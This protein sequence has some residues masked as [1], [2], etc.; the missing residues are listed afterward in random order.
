MP[1]SHG[2][3]YW[4]P[5]QA[6][7]EINHPH[8]QRIGT[9]AA[10]QKT[11][12]SSLGIRKDFIYS[13]GGDSASNSTYL[14]YHGGV[15]N[16]SFSPNGS[17]V[18]AATER[19]SLLLFDPFS[20]K[21]IRSVEGAHK[22]SVNYVKFLD[23]RLFATCSDDFCVAIWDLRNTRTKLK[24]LRGHSY[25][26]KNIEYDNSNGLLLT[27]SYDGCVNVWDINNTRGQRS[28]LSSE[29][30]PSVPFN[31]NYDF[32]LASLASERETSQTEIIDR[33]ERVLYLSCIMRMRLTPDASKM[34]VCTSEGY[35]MIVHD[36]DLDSLSTD[37]SGFQS[38]LYRLMQKGHSCGL[39]FGSWYNKLF[40]AKRN[41]VELISDFPTENDAHSITSLDVHPYNW[42]ILSRNI[43]RDEQSEWTCVHDIQDDRRPSDLVPISMPKEHL[44]PSYENRSPRVTLMPSASSSRPIEEMSTPEVTI[45]P[46]NNS[47]DNTSQRSVTTS[48]QANG[49]RPSY[50]PSS[51]L[52]TTT[53]HTN[54]PTE[55]SPPVAMHVSPVVI[56]SARTLNRRAHATIL[57][58]NTSYRPIGAGG[59]R[60]TYIYRNVPR[61]T[62][63]A[64]EMN[65]GQGYIKELSFSPDGRVICSPFDQGYRILSFNERCSEL[66]DIRDTGIP[67]QLYEV[68]RLQPH[69]ACVVTSKF[70]PTHPFVASGC[71]NGRVVFSQPVL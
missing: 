15:F 70:S 40:T 2:N 6:N 25:W 14:P 63:Y 62:N 23:D 28:R 51:F 54:S 60:R 32:P 8:H 58:P 33:C 11:I 66:C 67:R 17:V 1:K 44:V 39:D 16:L 4:C 7:R 53:S 22:D 61:L 52:S 42:C 69:N 10:F 27:S 56:I 49:A 68:K 3:R 29:N 48:S 55:S 18:V 20:H 38:D 35:I 43:S 13:Y 9:R 37:L 5:I 19:R 57:S 36:L 31:A 47:N 26:V 34:V 71:L 46:I 41:R 65:V 21:L 64:L 50:S 30:G 24:S 45:E 59:D 12:Y